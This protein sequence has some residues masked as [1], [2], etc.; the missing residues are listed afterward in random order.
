MTRKS[1]YRWRRGDTVLAAI[2][3]AV[4]LVLIPTLFAV[5]RAGTTVQVTVDGAVVARFPLAEERTYTIHGADGG[6]NTLVIR[7]G[8]AT[9]TDADCPD[10]LCVHQHAIS[11]A[12]QSIICLPH[13][14]VVTVVGGQPAVDGEV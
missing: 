2:V 1:E 8:Q 3:I 6:V 11:R 14:V 5:F 9:V 7:G 13:R 4:A 10:R 12:G